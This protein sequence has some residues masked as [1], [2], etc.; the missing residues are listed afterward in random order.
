LLPST[1]LSCLSGNT[2]TTWHKGRRGINATREQIAVSSSRD[3]DQTEI[4]KMHSEQKL[5]V[6]HHNRKESA[7]WKEKN[8][9]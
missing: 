9:E 1:Q 4:T 5:T 7:Y 6:R 2:N 8:K 3:R